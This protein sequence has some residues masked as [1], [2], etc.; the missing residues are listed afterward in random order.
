[1]N[2]VFAP[3]IVKHSLVYLDNIIVYSPLEEQHSKDLEAVFTT[4]RQ[5]RLL[6]K[7]SKCQ[8]FH[9]QV[10]SLGHVVSKDGIKPDV[11]KVCAISQMPSPKDK[12]ELRTFLGMIVYV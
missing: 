1:M 2:K 6:A 12:S 11:Q 10:P 4:L 7:P 8:F 5:H 3:H 9:E